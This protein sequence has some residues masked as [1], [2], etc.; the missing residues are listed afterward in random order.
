MKKIIGLVVILAVLVLGSYYGMGLATQRTLNRSV[1]LINQSTGVSVTVVDYK[2]HWFN[3]TAALDVNVHI[4][5]RVETNA[6]G[7]L[8]TTPAQ[9][10]SLAVPIDIIHGPIIY[11]KSGVLFG[12]GYAHSTLNLPKELAE[13]ISTQFAAQSTQPTFQLSVFVNYL[14]KSSFQLAVPTFKLVFKEGNGQVDW[15]GMNGNMS[16]SSDLKNFNGQFTLDGIKVVKDKMNGEVREVTSD[17]ALEKTDDGLFIGQ[18]GVSLPSMVVSQEGKPL[19]D[20]NQFKARTEST[21]TKGLFESSFKTSF[22]KIQ[23]NDKQYG[24]GLLELSIKNLDAKVLAQL[25]AQANTLK[26]TS[27]AQR[28]QTL[29]AM[30]PVLPKLFVQGA[31]FEIST[32]KLTVPEG[33]IDGHFALALPKSD[34]VNPF[35]LMQTL[36]G[37]GKLQVP[38]EIVKRALTESL[39]QKAAAE[40]SPQGKMLP[41]PDKVASASEPNGA[42]TPAVAENDGKNVQVTVT[43]DMAKQA[44]AEADKK[45]SA[46]VEAKLLDVQGPNYV[47]EFQLSQ[48]KF[49][50]NGQPFDPSTF[51][52]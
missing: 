15:L 2:R 20:L 4:P 50:V 19:F 39:K 9:D 28:Q 37:N 18:A 45:L 21:I 24:P 22:D 47:I 6:D 43:D 51:K 32:L 11:S 17:Y 36:E 35:Q 10:Y 46:L 27:G 48:G 8:E 42:A 38:S 14:N 7:K 3:S 31:A 1:D 5:E 12:L 26:H 40:T 49:I 44:A 33:D 29:F 30:L 41:H 25:N 23:A 13:K 16:V 52:L 34:N